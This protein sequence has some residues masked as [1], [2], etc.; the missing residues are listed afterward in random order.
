MRIV[1]DKS[2]WWGQSEERL[3][4]LFQNYEIVMPDSLLYEVLNEED[5]SVR[6][7]L[8]Q[9]LPAIG[10]P[11]LL[12]SV[13]RLIQFEVNNGKPYEGIDCGLEMYR[14]AFNPGLG[15]PDFVPTKKQRRSIREWDTLIQDE[16]TQFVLRMSNL[17]HWFP[18]LE[19]WQP[20]KDSAPIEQIKHKIATVPEE[21]IRFYRAVHV[22]GLPSPAVLDQNWAVFKW[23]QVQLLTGLDYIASYGK[24]AV[25]INKRIKNE[26]LDS[27][28]CLAAVIIGGLAT[29]DKALSKRFR[30]ITVDGLLLEE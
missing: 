17:I 8:F 27:E 23:L 25:E 9:K 7:R 10:N 13:H 22:K 1:L 5:K 16:S 4:A 6:A 24:D 3:L 14:W 12:F 18:E 2:Y 28:Y 30:L 20:G 15:D 29:R 19:K 21:V 26:L 11:F